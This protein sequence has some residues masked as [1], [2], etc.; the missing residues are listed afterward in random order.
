MGS[1]WAFLV[2]KVNFFSSNDFSLLPSSD[3]DRSIGVLIFS[4]VLLISVIKKKKQNKNFKLFFAVKLLWFKSEA[5]FHSN[6]F[7]IGNFCSCVIFI[8][9]IDRQM[10]FIDWNIHIG[11]KNLWFWWKLM[12]KQ[13]KHWSFVRNQ[14]EISMFFFLEN[15]NQFVD[16]CVQTNAIFWVVLPKW[17][18]NFGLYYSNIFW[19]IF[20]RFSI[21]VSFYRIYIPITT[22]WIEI[23][24][25]E[26]KEMLGAK[27][28]ENWKLLRIPKTHFQL[29]DFFLKSSFNLLQVFVD[30]SKDFSSIRQNYST[31]IYLFRCLENI[32]V[33][34]FIW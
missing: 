9:F 8:E 3:M 30:V 17:M 10:I 2:Y 21:R 32:N 12:K 28:F 24:L 31:D 25:W 33:S 11:S 5:T 22:N 7:S 4:L 6:S 20:R 1:R 19:W 34:A 16:A 26:A 15:F 29:F 23:E 14:F 13:N 18:W 27:M